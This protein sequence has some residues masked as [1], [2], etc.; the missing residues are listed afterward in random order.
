MAISTLACKSANY[1][2]L[3][4]PKWVMHYDGG[5]KRCGVGISRTHINGLP[6]QRALAISRAIDEIA[7]QQGVTVD[8]EL[9]SIISGSQNGA[10]SRLSTFSVQTTTGEKVEAEIM[11]TFM[12]NKS[13]ELYILMCTK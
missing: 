9:A 13:S 5:G 11:D 8:S 10:I 3:E 2:A 4:L 6:Y 12:D 1:S 7:K